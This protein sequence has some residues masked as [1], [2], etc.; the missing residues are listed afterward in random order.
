MRKPA[1]PGRV[2]APGM[3]E[4]EQD[5]GRAQRLRG[6]RSVLVCVRAEATSSAGAG[7]QRGSDR[8]GGGCT[9]Q[10]RVGLKRGQ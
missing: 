1:L 7:V 10:H 6:H 8:S 2:L 9:G 3:N 5:P 4:P